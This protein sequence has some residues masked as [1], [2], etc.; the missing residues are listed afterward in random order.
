[1]PAVPWICFACSDRYSWAVDGIKTTLPLALTSF[2]VVTC[3]IMSCRKQKNE[4]MAMKI[5]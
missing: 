2:A 3:S 1:M 4:S 5:K